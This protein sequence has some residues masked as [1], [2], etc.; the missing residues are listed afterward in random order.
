MRRLK[1]ESFGR[2]EIRIMISSKFKNVPFI[3]FIFH[4]RSLFW[5]LLKNFLRLFF[6]RSFFRILRL[7]ERILRWIFRLFR[8]IMFLFWRFSKR[9]LFFH[10]SMQ[11]NVINHDSIVISSSPTL[12]L[13]KIGSDLSCHVHFISRLAFSSCSLVHLIIVIHC[14]CPWT[15]SLSSY[16]GSRIE[17]KIVFA[18]LQLNFLCNI[19]AKGMCIKLDYLAW[20]HRN[21]LIEWVSFIDFK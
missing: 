14:Y 7:W 21:R 16:S 4:F 8:W 20:G 13:K 17:R 2:E 3:A 6:L 10:V 9:L 19:V 18:S 1:V 11:N 12:E 5:H 15:R